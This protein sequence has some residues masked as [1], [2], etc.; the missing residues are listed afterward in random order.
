M[1]P[2]T[3]QAIA[4][5]RRNDLLAEAAAARQ[6][7]QARPGRLTGQVRPELPALGRSPAQRGRSTAGRQPLREPRQV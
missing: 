3:A 1:H 7:N 5:Q 6:A 2:A 4:A